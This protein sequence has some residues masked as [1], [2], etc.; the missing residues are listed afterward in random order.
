[1]FNIRF[2]IFFLF[3]LIFNAESK[4]LYWYVA[5]SMTKPAKEIS[6]RFN[7]KYK[8][9]SMILITGGSGELLSK[10]YASKKGDLY[11]PADESFLKKAIQLGVIKK[12]KPILIQEPVFAFA[13][14]M[15]LNISNVSDICIENLTI[16]LGNP[17]TMALGKTFETMQKLMPEELYKCIKEKRK[18][19]PINISQTVNY[20]K[21]NV[22]D[23]GLLFKSTA[24]VNNLR[25]I[26]IPPKWNVKEKAYLSELIYSN[27]DNLTEKAIQFIEDNLDIFETSGF[28]I[29]K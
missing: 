12:Y 23:V 25:Y 5:A 6:Q 18:I 16:A 15:N 28:D 26:E 8:E 20:L 4:E 13:K 14:K 17:K 7:N 1:M 29:L 22:V 21:N 10:I 2:I 24:K 27:D 19:E 3:I 11:T 9:D